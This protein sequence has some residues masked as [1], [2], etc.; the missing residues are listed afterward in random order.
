M[1]AIELLP[2]ISAAVPAVTAALAIAAGAFNIRA[3]GRNI[4]SQVQSPTDGEIR[5]RIERLRSE[6]DRYSEQAIAISKHLAAAV[7]V[8]AALAILAVQ[9]L[10]KEAPG[11]TWTGF[12]L[13][14]GAFVVSLLSNFVRAT[15]PVLILDRQDLG[16]LDTEELTEALRHASA[17]G[18]VIWSTLVWRRLL[19]IVTFGLVFASIVCFAFGQRL[20]TTH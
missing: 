13:S 6:V 5:H 16:Q 1:F 7:A 14:L 8:T 17:D 4:P 19:L 10:H 15:F 2:T 3:T 12:F 18:R 20:V 9:L 11:E